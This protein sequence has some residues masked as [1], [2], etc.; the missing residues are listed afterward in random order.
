MS[1]ASPIAH[2]PRA[3]RRLQA[4]SP[5]VA[6]L[7]AAAVVIGVILYLGRHALTPFI[8][9]LL[10]IYILDPA[11]TFFSRL[12]IGRWQMP[13][14]LA[15]LLVYIITFALI[16]VGLSF[17]LG[18]LVA[19]V[20][21]YVRNLPELL[22]SLED[23][24]D[25]LGETYRGLGLPPPIRE[26]IDGLL[27]DV[28]Q[29]AGD[30]DFGSLL[31]IARTLLGTVAGFFGFIIIP[32]WAFYILRDRVRLAEQFHAML[33]PAWRPDTL[34]VVTIIERVF[35]RWIRGQ[36]LLGVIIGAATY[37]G[38]LL[39]GF[40]VDERFLQFAVLLA[41]VA[42]VL[43]LLPIIGPIIS[44]VPT[45]L[46]AMTTGEPLL[47]VLAV[48]GLYTVIQQV[49]GAILVPKIQGEAVELHP[50][51]VIFALIIGAAIA[52]LPGAIF[53]I[54]VAAAGK[55]VYRY[56]FRR[57]SEDDPSVPAADA[58]DLRAFI[59]HTELASPHEEDDDRTDG[60]VRPADS[61]MAADAAD[62]DDAPEAPRSRGPV[63]GA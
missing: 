41:V 62:R 46:V 36:I 21:E 31:P 60:S 4:P 24:L 30:I 44:M 22:R 54:P 45:L 6:L 53:S 13:R 35:G 27:Q 18:P 61:P 3:P 47:S 20:L 39:L 23:F 5:R 57:L 2:A 33:P 59:E 34:A 7:I 43:E 52:G 1:G 19:Q 8:V 14:G 51:V 26:Y 42:G 25:R 15:V 50:S 38:L 32:I 58:P 48:V 16:F 12:R 29:G 56:L 28:G 37:G 10:L 11:V 63:S 49:E 9:G 55:S 40:A 17:L